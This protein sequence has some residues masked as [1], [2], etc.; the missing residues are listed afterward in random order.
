MLPR[1]TKPLSE[2]PVLL[3]SKTARV[4][5]L[6]LLGG[7]T[8][9][10]FAPILV[11]LSELGPVATAFYRLV[12]AQPFLWLW[13]YVE[14][15]H[16]PAERPIL[17]RSDYGWLLLCG[18]LFALEIA[19]W[20]GSIHLT[21][22]ANA[23]LLANAAPIFV[24]LGAWI[25][26]HERITGMFIT[27][28][29]IAIVGAVLLTGASFHLSSRHLAGDL[30]GITTAI[31]Y[32]CYML[33]VKK[34]RS[35]FSTATLMAWAGIASSLSLL[36]ASA[37]AGE[38]LLPRTA[39]GWAVLLALALVSQVLGQGLIAYAFA[40]LPASFSSLTLLLQ[41]VIAALLA[42][43]LLRESMSLPQLGGGILVLAGIAFSQRKRRISSERTTH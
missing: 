16:S 30:L 15:R 28:L 27:G 1:S 17:E 22:V 4:A 14:K 7:A 20:H 42:W 40:H 29:L 33:C 41:P 8:G 6:S 10:A 13:V 34:L 36:A 19:L 24:T 2:K 37:A 35:K 21:A 26:F 32:G 38:N 39:N 3:E 25:F 5:L 12:L 18:M 31:F 9:I 23:T 43:I 11:R